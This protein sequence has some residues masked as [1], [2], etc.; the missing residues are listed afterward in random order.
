MGEGIGEFP[1]TYLSSFSFCS[2]TLIHFI[3]TSLFIYVMHVRVPEKV[4]MYVFF[5]YNKYCFKRYRSGQR[6]PISPSQE[7]VIQCDRCFCGPYRMF[8]QTFLHDNVARW[9][10]SHFSSDIFQSIYKINV[11]NSRETPP[12]F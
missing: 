5:S 10:C 3:T 12:Q 6:S 2:T 4:V 7:T 9:L 8:Y 1:Y 11:A